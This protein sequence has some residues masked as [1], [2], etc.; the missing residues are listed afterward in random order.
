MQVNKISP[1]V[2]KTK[3]CVGVCVYVLWGV[4][5]PLGEMRCCLPWRAVAVQR[6]K[7]PK[8]SQF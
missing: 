4:F 5:K 6:G 3:L 8:I 2:I 1:Y 7:K